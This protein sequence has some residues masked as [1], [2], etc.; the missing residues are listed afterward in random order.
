MFSFEI[1]ERDLGW[2]YGFGSDQYIQVVEVLRSVQNEK[3]RGLRIKY[4]KEERGK[5]NGEGQLINQEEI[6]QKMVLFRDV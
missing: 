1:Q 3:N 4:C 2:K 6:Q 5:E